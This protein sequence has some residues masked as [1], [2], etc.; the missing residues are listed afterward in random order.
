MSEVLW[1]DEFCKVQ[2]YF[3]NFTDFQIEQSNFELRLA[4]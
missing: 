2:E 3:L 1:S 4:K